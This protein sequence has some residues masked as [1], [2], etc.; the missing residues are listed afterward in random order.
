MNKNI[1]IVVLVVVILA[2]GGYVIFMKK[3]P[4]PAQTPVP[5]ASQPKQPSLV[6]YT[7]PP[8]FAPSFLKYGPSELKMPFP[9]NNTYVATAL[10]VENGKCHYI[11][12]VVDQN[13]VALNGIDCQV[14]KEL[15][16]TDIL[17][18]VFGNDNAP[19]KEKILAAQNKIEADH[20]Q[21]LGQ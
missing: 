18:H 6:A 1:I 14:P 11:L 17:D 21:K 13:G 7:D 15:I 19:G 12:K 10:G 9:G 5:A 20:C 3:G 8:S 4:A 2:G 16:T